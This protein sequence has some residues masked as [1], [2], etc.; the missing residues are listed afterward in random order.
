MKKIMFVT[1]LILSVFAQAADDAKQKR[2]EE[3]LA[4]M[5]MTALIDQM[6]SQL[7]VQLKSM[8]TQMGVKPEDKPI[9]DKY[10]GKMIQL[11]KNE[12]TWDK[13]K[14]AL[15]DVYSRN[16]SE[17]EIAD[18]IAFYE[19]DTGKAVIKKM[20]EV[21][22]QSMQVTSQLYQPIMPELQQL[23]KDFA[24]ELQAS[25]KATTK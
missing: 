12:I 15:I 6:Y 4:V 13:M 9:V 16:F 10:Y 11:F 24:A 7:E 22:Q 5:N 17:K 23:S 18:M 14:P 2:L 21:M 8:S 20:P 25:R 19:T 1:L 3:L